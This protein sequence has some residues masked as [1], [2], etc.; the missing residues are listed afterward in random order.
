MKQRN[1]HPRISV[2]LKVLLRRKGS[3][4]VL[5]MAMFVVALTGMIL[6]GL[7]A[8]QEIA[9]REMVEST[10]IRCTVTNAKGSGVD[11]LGVGSFY[12]DMLVGLRHSRDCYL[13][14]CV[15]DVKALAWE[16]L[17]QPGGSEIRRIYTADSDPALSAINGGTVTFY[18]GWSEDCLIGSG[19]V[20]LVTGD[21]LSEAQT[22]SNGEAYVTIIRKNGIE[23]TLKVIGTVTGQ[24]SRRIYCP[25]YT[26]IQGGNSEAFPLAS[27]SFT[28]KDNEF[29]EESRQALYEYFV[30][31]SP[32]LSNSFTEAGLLVHDEIYL[33]SM[34][35]F[36][37]NLSI[38][39]VILPVLIVFAGCVGFLS[40]YLT[41][42]GR[43]KEFAI[44]RCIGIRRSGVFLQVFLEQSLLTVCGCGVGMILSFFLQETI[45]IRTLGLIVIL[46]VVCLLGAAVA[47]WHISSINVMKLMKVEE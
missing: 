14:E 19:Q 40:A 22:D 43:Q 15:K 12:V 13:D 5:L 16:K 37:N 41:N 36:E 2:S 32:R 46:L 18:D 23:T 11:D 9:I 4:I 1:G 28:V 33:R 38:L 47:V 44:M 35:E 31:P 17:A 8:R 26:N 25:F 21:I 45:F 10:Q 39:S 7:Q 6:C 27:C 34:E 30:Y 3:N 24:M 29:L 42:R 20:C